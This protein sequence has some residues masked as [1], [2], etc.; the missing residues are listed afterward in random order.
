[1]SLPRPTAIL[2]D[3]DNTLVDG[4]AAIAEGLAA[5]FTAFGLPVWTEEEVKARVRRSLRESFPEIF[6]PDWE[7]ARDI[8][9]AG[10]RARHL[11]VLR[12][13]PGAAALVAAAARL[14][15]VAVV[16]NKQGPLLRAE[17]VHLGWAEH[18]RA[19]VGAGDA[20]ADKPDPAPMRMALGPCGVPADGRVWYVGDTALD[21][22][23]AR[24]AGFAA[25]LLGDAA[26][27]GGIAA[28]A[29]DAAFP[30]GHALAAW[31]IDDH[32]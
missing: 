2:F 8:F 1:M 28:A 14:V 17:A 11:E 4:W 19:L 27:D 31:L 22:Q 6:G 16:S 10:V 24:R 3:W 30:D 20:A 12:P 18:F 23:A 7:R 32:D 26:H 9:Y 13:M 29:P 25:V 5:A 15:P 21:M